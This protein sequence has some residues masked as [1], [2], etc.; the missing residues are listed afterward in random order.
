MALTAITREVN[1]AMASCELTFLPRVSIDT[2][3]AQ[4]QHQN[5][6]SVLSSLSVTI[7]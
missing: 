5:Y 2:A 7:E 4:Q 3:L 1:T 6:H